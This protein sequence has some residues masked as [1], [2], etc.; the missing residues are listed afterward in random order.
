MLGA[1]DILAPDGFIIVQHF[2]KDDLPDA[3]GDLT[4]FRQ[5]K[6]GDTVL[7]FYKRS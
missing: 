1:C 3:L 5:K 2:K 7:S 6:Y 4:L